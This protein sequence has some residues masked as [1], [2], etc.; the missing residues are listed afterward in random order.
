MNRLWGYRSRSPGIGLGIF[1]CI[2][3]T[4]ESL[5]LGSSDF[6]ILACL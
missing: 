6:T 5:F 2:E 4:S 3:F 1:L